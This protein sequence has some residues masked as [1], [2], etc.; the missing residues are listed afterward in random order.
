M[1]NRWSKYLFI[2]ILFFSCTGSFST[3]EE[4]NTEEIPDNKALK[5]FIS[6]GVGKPLETKNTNITEFIKTAHKYL[7]TPHCMGGNTK[8][9]TDCS[10]FLMAVFAEHHVNL[11][12]NSQEQARYGK[13]ILSKNKLQKGDLVF[14]TNTYATSSYITHAGIYLGNNTFIHASSSKGVT[15]TSLDNSWWEDKYVFGTRVF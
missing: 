6:T 13:M 2:F 5:A 8:K 9:C 3:H 10:G 14:F 11:P 12:H 1:N 15:I 4:N 7:G